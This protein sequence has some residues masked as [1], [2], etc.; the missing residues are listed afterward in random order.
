MAISTPPVAAL[1]KD[2]DIIT[3]GRPTIQ[4]NLRAAHK[5]VL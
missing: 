2:L 1:Q 4:R 3:D 5:I